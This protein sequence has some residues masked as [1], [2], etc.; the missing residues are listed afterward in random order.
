M[1]G[2][3]PC[4]QHVNASEPVPPPPPYHAHL[5]TTKFLVPALPGTLIPRPRLTA[6]LDAG[7]QQ[8]LILVSA[9]AGFGKTTLLAAW[10]RSFASGTR[11]VAWVSLDAGDN[12]PV[13]FWAYVLTAL[14]SCQPGLCTLPFAYL[15][16]EPQPAWQAM[17]TALINRLAQRSKRILLVLD[18]YEAIT[19]PAIHALVSFLVEHL[20]PSLCVVLATRADPPFSLARL[21]VRAQ[22]QELRTEQLQFT[23][24]E[25]A[26][27]LREGMHL[28]LSAQ[29]MQE[30]EARTQ[31]W[32]AGLQLAA[33]ALR[34]RANPMDLLRELQGSQRAIREYLV[35]EVLQ[36]QPADLQTFLLRTSLLARLS[37]SLCDTMLEQP[38]NQQVLEELERANLF[39]SPLD[40]RHHWYAY[41]PL[42]AEALHSQLEQTSPAEVPVLHL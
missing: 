6:L 4:E 18:N 41:H 24:E 32:W 5:L 7:L 8:P 27:F 30:V 39:L 9:G 2:N 35:H 22:V 29:E 42:F 13:Q 10:V 34:G 12:I 25:A 16:E 11:P 3:K 28:H 26:V 21:R 17:L 33:L 36:R 37:A 20:P 40:R 1:M 38:G 15:Y 23:P 31:G 14:E 19:E